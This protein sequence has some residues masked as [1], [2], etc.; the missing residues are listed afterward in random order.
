M[1]VLPLLGFRMGVHP[2]L[3]VEDG[4]TTLYRGSGWQCY[5]Y[6]GVQ[7]GGR[8]ICGTGWGCFPYLS[9]RMGVHPCLGVQDGGTTLYGA[10]GWGYIPIWG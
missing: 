3:W 9:C 10:A 2:Y 8:S 1:G 5:P 4:G 6:L 7:D